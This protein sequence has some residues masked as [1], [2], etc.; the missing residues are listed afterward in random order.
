MHRGVLHFYIDVSG[1][2][3]GTYDV[4]ERHVAIDPA[5]YTH[6][7]KQE[8]DNISQFLALLEVVPTTK[9]KRA[10]PFMDFTKSKILTS[11]EYTQGCKEVL[12]QCLAHEVE[13]KQKATVKEANRETRLRE[14]EERQRDVR[15]RAIAKEAQRQERQWL[16][17]EKKMDGGHRR[18][19]GAGRVPTNAVTSLQVSPSNM[20]DVP[21]SS[22]YFWLLSNNSMNPL[23]TPLNCPSYFYNQLLVP[24]LFLEG[25]TTL[26]LNE[27]NVNGRI[28]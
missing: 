26:N 1:V 27:S 2:V 23:S 15:E 7:Q 18:C 13:T 16:E 24:H 6:L 10:Q 17:S 5:F 28:P 11:A 25:T 4:Q 14:K 22:A 12:A 3:E 19:Q 21:F 9:R 8:E 20:S